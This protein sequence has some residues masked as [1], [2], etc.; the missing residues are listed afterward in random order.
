MALNKDFKVKDTINVG[1]SG[2]F[3][4]GVRIGS[5]EQYWNASENDYYTNPAIDAWGPILSGGRDLSDFIGDGVDGI[6]EGTVSQG[7]IEFSRQT[8][9]DT[10]ADYKSNT[11]EVLGLQETDAPT[12]TDLFLTGATAGNVSRIE[13][14]STLILDPVS[15]TYASG[16]VALTS[17]DDSGTTIVIRA[18]KPGVNFNIA[19]GN[20]DA[21][22]DGTNTIAEALDALAG[23]SSSDYY[24]LKQSDNSD[25][26]N[27][28]VPSGTTDDGILGGIDSEADNAVGGTVV[29][30][31]DLQ[32]DGSTTTVNSSE[33]TVSDSTI[34]I[35]KD[36]TLASQWTGAAVIVGSGA[37]NITLTD[38]GGGGTGSYWTISDD[39]HIGDANNT[40][41]IKGAGNQDLS[42]KTGHTNTGEIKIAGTGVNGDVSLLPHGTG[43]I[44]VGGAGNVTTDATSKD[45]KLDTGNG[46]TGGAITIAAATAG[47]IS[48]VPNGTGDIVVG[49]STQ[50][51]DIVTGG[52]TNLTLKTGAVN[53]GTFSIVQGVDGDITLAPDGLGKV[54][55]KSGSIVLGTTLA[56]ATVTTGGAH[57]LILNTNGGTNSGSITITDGVNGDITLAPNGTGEVNI[58]S[59]QTTQSVDA[60]VTSASVTNGVFSAA[61]A[62]AGTVTLDTVSSDNDAIEAEVVI[63]KGAEVQMIKLLAVTDGTNVDGT[64]FGE[65]TVGNNITL[66]DV[67]D[68]TIV[69]GKYRFSLGT[70]GTGET[71]AT[72]STDQGGN[73]S[74]EDCDL[75]VTIRAITA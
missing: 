41:R 35:A 10:D 56:N 4:S 59:T 15:Q 8:D 24:F 58:T 50:G 49:N 17:G 33:L 65:V 44:V 68:V 29:I 34:T 14:A 38:N 67:L 32:V 9:T 45:L 30:K 64:T 22:F 57:D 26:S 6:R 61:V 72:G 39:V 47:N 2:L 74:A 46:A 55:L 28:V 18:K 12:F 63:R 1:V 70:A 60:T 37:Q 43:K 53:T 36:A 19:D 16:E 31:G 23:F 52:N 73:V 42:L 62:I 75:T 40:A 11:V 5:S 21:Q 54:N 51:A 20:L 48:I 69:G 3:G 13:G 25:A 71:Q 27:I 66:G 7:T